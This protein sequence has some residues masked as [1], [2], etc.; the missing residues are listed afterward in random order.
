MSD[1]SEFSIEAWKKHIK[2][3]IIKQMI[4]A[5]D[6]LSHEEVTEQMFD[7]M[8]SNLESGIEFLKRDKVGF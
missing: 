3:I 2:S 4:V 5:V 7:Y 1:N 8:V 6:V